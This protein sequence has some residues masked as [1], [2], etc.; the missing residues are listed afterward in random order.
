MLYWSVSVSKEPLTF[1]PLIFHLSGCSLPL[2][3]TGK[4]KKK[5][6]KMTLL[7]I[8]VSWFLTGSFSTSLVSQ[9][10]PSPVREAPAPPR[11]NALQLLSQGPAQLPG[12][13]PPA[14]VWALTTHTAPESSP[15]TPAPTSPAA[16][17]G[18]RS[19]Q[20]P[21]SPQSGQTMAKETTANQ[22]PPDSPPAP[23]APATGAAAASLPTER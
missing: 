7:R 22:E 3:T 5:P 10:I 13:S 2:H 23:Q 19:F 4:K 1:H 21:S 15:D 6:F 11:L 17:C 8:W 14:R 18:Q 9:L 20:H 12:S 16:R